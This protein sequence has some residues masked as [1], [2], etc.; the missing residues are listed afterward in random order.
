MHAPRLIVA[1]AALACAASI[2]LAGPITP[3]P[4]PVV[5][6]P[7]PEPRVAINLTNTPGDSNSVFRI[8]QPGSYYLAGNVSGVSGKSGIEIAASGVTIDLNGFALTG[9]AGSLQGIVVS[10]SLDNLTVRNGTVSG[11]AGTGVLLGFAATESGRLVE[12]VHISDN[13][14]AGL[15]CGRRSIVR[16]CTVSGN[17]GIGI[18]STEHGIFVACLVQGNGADGFSLGASCRVTDCTSQGNG[19]DGFHAVSNDVQLVGC[20]ATGNGG[21]GALSAGS[22][23]IS[24]CLMSDNTLNGIRV[25]GNSTLT[26]NVCRGNGAGAGDGAGILVTGSDC[27]VESNSCMGNDRGIEVSGSGCRVDG[28]SANDNTSGFVITGQDN[29]VIRNTASGNTTNYS[30]GAGNAV[31]PRVNVTASDGWAGITNAAHPWANFGY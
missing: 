25:S 7:G 15:A 23:L 4:G 28:N 20:V 11:W 2:A 6:T 21:E 3:P 22:V 24:E 26:G 12:S 31:A 10:G 16:N 14:G 18:A 17:T 30:I 1:L 9:V 8:T 13:A 29:I 27:R 19:D 5:S